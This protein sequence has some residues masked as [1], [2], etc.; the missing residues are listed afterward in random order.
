MN[1]FTQLF[2][3][4]KSRGGKV[5]SGCSSSNSSSSGSSSTATSC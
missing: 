1:N 4:D 3:R 2:L 5:A